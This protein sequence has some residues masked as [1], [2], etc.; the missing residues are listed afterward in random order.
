MLPIWEEKRMKS[1]ERWIEVFKMCNIQENSI[2]N[3]SKLVE[4]GF[5]LPG[6]ST[7]IERLF[8]VIFNTLE[9]ILNI[10]FNSEMTCAEFYKANKND[11]D[12]LMEVLSN[13]KY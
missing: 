11:K 9:E 3:L 13:E 10:K 4:F 1:D 7:E 8:S 12:M 6:T 5:C 2:P